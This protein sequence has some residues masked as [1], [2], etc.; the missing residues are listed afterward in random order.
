MEMKDIEYIKAI[1]EC[2]SLTKAA[3]TLYISQPSLSM[4]LKNMNTRLG[5]SVFNQIGKKFELTFLG[6]RFLAAGSEILRIRDDF[7]D[8]A[9]TI[10]DN[11][12]GRLRVSIPFMRGS[13]LAPEILPKFNEIYPN[14]TVELLEESSKVV[15]EKIN[16]GEADIAIMN[17]PH[18]ALHL[19][20]EVIKTEEILLA[21][22]AN[23]P[24]I[25]EGKANPHSNYPAID[26][27]L[28]EKDRFIL[29]FPDQRTGQIAETIF[30]EL[31]FTPRQV[32]HTRNIETAVNLT[33]TG[34]G[35]SFV[36]ETHIRHL[37]FGNAPRFFSIEGQPHYADMIVA[38][39][40]GR[41]LPPYIK[42]LIALCKEVV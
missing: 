7:Y 31:A 34:Y 13:Y 11:K 17:K 4:Y 23:H 25:H 26:L 12:I 30:T 3:E 5:F 2:K 32:I 6:E 20:Y 19:D 8:E 14:I 16:N 36:N 9:A 10:L 22:P 27:R 33:V 37:K 28:F 40:K 1:H 35:V 21:V 18:H 39:R 38:Y 41:T 29:H 24:Y 15:E 42:T